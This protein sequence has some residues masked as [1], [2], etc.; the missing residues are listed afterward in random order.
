MNRGTDKCCGLV[1]QKGPGRQSTGIV[2]CMTQK[3]TEEL[4]DFL[5]DRGI[6]ADFYH[7][8]QS[9]TDRTNV[10]TAWQRGAIKVVCATIAYGMG[11]D[12]PDVRYVV[13]L[14]IAKSLEGYYQ[15]AGRAGRD[16]QRS[17]C[18]LFYRQY[19]AFCCSRRVLML[20]VRLRSTACCDLKLAERTLQ[21]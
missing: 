15:E 7:A 4:A 12:K 19:V 16:G 14:S 6:A 13:H 8:G 9:K 3:D 18:I 2:Y 10:Q 21:S 5:R 17:D 1:K 20:A 11:I